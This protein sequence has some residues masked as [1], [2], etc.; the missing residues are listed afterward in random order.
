MLVLLGGVAFS[1]GLVRAVASE[2]P[3]LDPAAQRS[4]LNGAI[5]AANGHSVL[6]VLQGDESR[7]LLKNISDVSPIMRQAIVSVEDRRFYEH[8][9]VDA[10]RNRPGAVEGHPLE[11]RRRRRVDDHAAVREER[12]HHE[13][14]DDRAQGTGTALA[15]QLE[16][17]WSK[18]RILLAYLNTIYFGNGAYGIQQAAR[19]Y[20]GKGAK[21]LTLAEATLLAGLPADPFPVRPGATSARVEAA[22]P[23]RAADDVRPGEDH[24]PSARDAAAAPLPEPDDVRLPGTRGPAQYFVNYVRDQLSRSTAP[25]ASSAAGSR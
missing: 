7:V 17:R 10:R 9:G 12:L 5:Y 25:R 13:P 23:V 15:W 2:I 22:P 20:F 21:R 3:Q 11:E 14:A 19:T 4:E 24:D 8:N 1:F 6:A 16:Q 18:D